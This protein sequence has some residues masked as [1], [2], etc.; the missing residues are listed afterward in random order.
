[1]NAI[2]SDLLVDMS[3]L[4]FNLILKASLDN[5]SRAYL[6]FELLITEFLTRHQIVSEPDETRVPVGKVI[7]RHIL[8]MSNEHFS[9]CS[10]SSSSV[11][12]PCTY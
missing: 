2:A 5:S 6:P 7:L 1:M 4:M 8:R 10:S 3:C 9:V 12:T 11:S